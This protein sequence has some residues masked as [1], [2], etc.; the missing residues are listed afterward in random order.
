MKTSATKFEPFKIFTLY[1]SYENVHGLLGDI[2]IYVF[3]EQG[4]MLE[5]QTVHRGK[6]MIALTE[7]SWPKA[8]VMLAP[9]LEGA[10]DGTLTISAAKNQHAFEVDIQ[11]QVAKASYKLPAVPEATWRWWLVHSLWTHLRR[12]TS[13]DKPSL[14]SW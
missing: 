13:L 12:D 9:P 8:R 14:L 3:D 11:F 10:I 2:R 5:S 6:A 7:D 4:E 1:P